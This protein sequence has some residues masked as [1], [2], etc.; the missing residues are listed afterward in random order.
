MFAASMIVL[1]ATLTWGLAA[2]LARAE[3]GSRRAQASWQEDRL[4]NAAFEEAPIGIALTAL[5]GRFTRVDRALCA[6]TGYSAEDL[7]GTRFVDL[8][9]PHDRDRATGS[10]AALIDGRL[11]VYHVQK[12][13]LHRDGQ[14]I[15]VRVTVTTICDQAGRVAQFQDVTQVGLAAQRVE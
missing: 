5:D 9:H 13:Y 3:L 2:S 8:T 12:R 10:P 14:V 11:T 4:G 15:H 6:M 7:I 1:L